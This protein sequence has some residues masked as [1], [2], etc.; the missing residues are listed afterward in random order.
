VDVT[1]S[2]A[3]SMGTSTSTSISTFAV[4]GAA[5]A[6]SPAAA[7]SSDQK[8]SQQMPHIPRR[9]RHSGSSRVEKWCSDAVV[10]QPGDAMPRHICGQ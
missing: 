4:A 1:T 5:E 6:A 8:P 7:A 2:E 3:T 9:Y 10:G